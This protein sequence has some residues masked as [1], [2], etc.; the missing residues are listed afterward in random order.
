MLRKKKFIEF[1]LSDEDQHNELHFIFL[2]GLINYSNRNRNCFE[3]TS[4]MCM[5]IL[6]MFDFK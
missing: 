1:F 3:F 6:N 5:R 4:F 2:Y